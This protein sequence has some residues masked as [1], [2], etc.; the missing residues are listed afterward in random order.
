MTQK[1]YICT[2]STSLRSAFSCLD[3]VPVYAFRVH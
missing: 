1:G 2:V 3:G